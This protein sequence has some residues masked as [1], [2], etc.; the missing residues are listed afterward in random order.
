MTDN[1]PFMAMMKAGQDW[2]R[3]LNP[4]LES[5][6]PKGF[7][8]LWPTMSREMMETVMG[9]TF[10]PDGLDAKTRL[11]C[12]LTGLTILGAQAESQVR[13]TVRHAVEAGATK[14]EIAETIAQAGLF[15]GVPAMTKAMEL[16]TEVLDGDEGEQGK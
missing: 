3:S 1:N 2:A 15:G 6:T 10:N 12:T 8:T 14:Q 7:E 16:A 13:L 9:K 11:L 5:F 4:A